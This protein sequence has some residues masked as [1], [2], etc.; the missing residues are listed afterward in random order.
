MAERGQPTLYREEYCAEVVELGK[1]G[2]SVAQMCAHFDIS[3]QTIDNWADAN[4]AFLE[5]LN[6]A[7]VHM[8]AKLEEMGFSG[9]TDKNFNAAVWKKTME[10]RFRD[11]YTERKEVNGNLA[12]VI[13]T[14]ADADL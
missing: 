3:R 8:Q 6:R 12:A 10:A 7:K 11:D 2:K 5:A 14:S 4:P 9:L 13:L 1:L